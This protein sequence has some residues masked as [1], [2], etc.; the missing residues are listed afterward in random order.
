[1]RTYNFHGLDRPGADSLAEELRGLG[2]IVAV[3]RAGRR[4]VAGWAVEAT[5]GDQDEVWLEVLARVYGGIYERE[6]L[7]GP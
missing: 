4:P 7:T 5:G 3:I 6:D 2:L 1:M